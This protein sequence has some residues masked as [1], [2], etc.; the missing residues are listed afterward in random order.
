VHPFGVHTPCA[1]QLGAHGR[2]VLQSLTTAP[3]SN[4]P[5]ATIANGCVVPSTT[6][7]ARTM[8]V[9][10]PAAAKVMS[11]ASTLLVKSGNRTPL[12][13]ASFETATEE[14]LCTLPNMHVPSGVHT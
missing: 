11:T 10:H 5:V 3:V 12:P 6:C 14:L 8:I 7:D 2:A 13:C 4:W 9:C 1:A